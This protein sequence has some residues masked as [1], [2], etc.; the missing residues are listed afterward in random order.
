MF[1]VSEEMSLSKASHDLIA[2]Q[3]FLVKMSLGKKV[4]I[5]YINKNLKSLRKTKLKFIKNMM[6]NQFLVKCK[7]LQ[8]L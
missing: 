8:I 6:T 3:F 7:A 1:Y 2:K 5:F 4:M